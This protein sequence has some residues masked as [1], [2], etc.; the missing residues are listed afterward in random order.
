TLIC[1]ANCSTSDGY[2]PIHI[3]SKCTDHTTGMS[4]T[5]GQRTD[6]ISLNNGSYFSIA[7]KGRAFCTLSL[8]SGSGSN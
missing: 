6:D 5:V 2:T 8:S 1:I 3:A 4:I 7:N